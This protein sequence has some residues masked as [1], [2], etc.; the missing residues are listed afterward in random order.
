MSRR[1][2]EPAK[3][4]Y[5]YRALRPHY[6]K[7]VVAQILKSFKN[8]PSAS[9]QVSNCSCRLV[10]LPQR[11]ATSSRPKMVRYTDLSFLEGQRVTN[12][13]PN[14][15]AT[16]LLNSAQVH[17][18]LVELK[19]ERDAQRSFS[20]YAIHR[21]ELDI[22]EVVQTN[23]VR[24]QPNSRLDERNEVRTPNAGRTSVCSGYQKSMSKRNKRRQSLSTL[25]LFL[26]R[27]CVGED[28]NRN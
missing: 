25:V 11:C 5:D 16:C 13:P 23:P 14:A 9:Q 7:W 6:P 15:V 28:R 12:L 22:E 20:P 17:P 27:I 4:R 24:T 10:V 18:M 21:H 1:S 3:H 26:L 2:C 8:S 19:N